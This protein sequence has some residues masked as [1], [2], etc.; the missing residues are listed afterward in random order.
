MT[1][2]LVTEVEVIAVLVVVMT[3]VLLKRELLC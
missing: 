1:A 2:V 3:A